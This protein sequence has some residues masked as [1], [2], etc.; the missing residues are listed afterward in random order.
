LKRPNFP[1]PWIDVLGIGDEVNNNFLDALVGCDCQMAF[2]RAGD[3]MVAVTVEGWMELAIAGEP[4]GNDRERD[5]KLHA[6]RRAP[7]RVRESKAVVR[8]GEEPLFSPFLFSR[9]ESDECRRCLSGLDAARECHR[10]L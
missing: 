2:L 8:V 1:H 5:V 9:V 7:F 4:G 10:A 3:K 6:E